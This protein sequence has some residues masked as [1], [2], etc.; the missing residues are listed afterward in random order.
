ML[1]PVAGYLAGYSGSSGTTRG[2]AVLKANLLELLE[3][4]RVSRRLRGVRAAFAEPAPVDRHGHGP[5]RPTP[6][7][8]G[9][10]G[11]RAKR[12]GQSPIRRSA[13]SMRDLGVSEDSLRFQVAR[14]RPGKAAILVSRCSLG[15]R[16][17][18]RQLWD[19]PGTCGFDSHNAAIRRALRQRVSA[20]A[21]SCQ[22]V[23]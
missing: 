11:R 6:T 4:P 19:K 1:A 20:R 3:P 12:P 5:N 17:I 10:R 21:G 7:E 9:D 8:P 23:R 18:P 15:F 16:A 22:R 14:E 13:H 2:R